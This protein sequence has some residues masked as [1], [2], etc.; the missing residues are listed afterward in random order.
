[1][2]LNDGPVSNDLRSH[3]SPVSFKLDFFSCRSPVSR[4]PRKTCIPPKKLKVREVP[5]CSR[6]FKISLHVPAP[7]PYKRS[8]VT[9][10]FRINEGLPGGVHVPLFPKNKLRCSLKFTF[11]KFPC[12]QKFCCM[13]P[14]FPEIL[15]NVPQNF[16]HIS[17]FDGQYFRKFYLVSHSRDNPQQN[18]SFVS[19]MNA[20]S[21][22]VH[23]QK[24]LSPL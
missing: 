7:Y 3:T 21:P 11:I 5:H 9:S 6:L 10:H 2:G 13:F 19:L 16:N 15:I 14:W 12:S 17:V 1:M 18:A 8:D 20:A 24:F 22:L 23:Q 4:W